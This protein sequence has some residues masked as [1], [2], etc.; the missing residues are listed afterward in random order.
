MTAAPHWLALLFTVILAGQVIANGDDD[1]GKIVIV[2]VDEQPLASVTIKLKV[3]GPLT[4]VP[5]PA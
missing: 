5:V 1:E 2:A 3:P 4:N